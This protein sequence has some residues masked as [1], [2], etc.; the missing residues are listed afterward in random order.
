MIDLRNIFLPD[1]DYMLIAVA[2]YSIVF[3]AAYE[4]FNSLVKEYSSFSST[5]TARP[6]TTYFRYHAAAAIYSCFYV[7]LFVLIYQLFLRYPVLIET[8][9]GGFDFGPKTKSLFDKLGDDLKLLS[10]MLTVILLTWGFEQINRTAK[11]DRKVRSFLHK[12][13]SIPGAVSSQVRKMRRS[14][15]NSEFDKCFKAF[16]DDLKNEVA[17][18]RNDQNSIEHIFERACHLYVHLKDWDSLT[19]DFYHY[20]AAHRHAFESIKVSFE[21]VGNNAE[22]YYQ[23]KSKFRKDAQLYAQLAEAKPELKLGNIQPRLITELKGYLREDLKHLLESI[24]IYIACAVYSIGK[25]ENRRNNLLRTMGF[26]LHDQKKGNRLGI[27]PNDLTIVFMFLIIVIPL[28]AI[29]AH[30][31]SGGRFVIENAYTHVVWTIMAMAVGLISV[32]VPTLCKQAREN[33]DGSFW[34]FLRPRHGDHAWFAYLLSGS[35]VGLASFMVLTLLCYLTPN[36]PSYEIYGIALRIMPWALVPFAVAFMLCFHLDRKTTPKFNS[37]GEGLATSMA[38]VLAG[39]VAIILSANIHSWEELAKRMHFS[40]PAAALLGFIIGSIFP[41]RYR[42]KATK[43]IELKPKLVDLKAIIE[44]CIKKFKNRADNEKIKI[45]GNVAPNIKKLKLDPNRIEQAITSLISNAIE[46]TPQGGQITVSANIVGKSAIHL[47][48]RDSGIGMSEKKIA[49]VVN[50][51]K[52]RLNDAWRDAE[53]R[54]EADLY[55]IRFIA[56]EHGGRFNVKSTQLEGT[57]VMIELPE[58]LVIEGM[59]VDHPNIL[60]E[61]VVAEHLQVQA[62]DGIEFQGTPESNTCGAGMII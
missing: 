53:E 55:Q 35:T 29:F 4:R 14:P 7:I 47:S 43:P 12:L 38:A 9:K 49:A 59:S 50:A 22:R 28:A 26:E 54:Q 13:G 20:H 2:C 31:I 45:I 32:V 10:P 46:F 34:Q 48:V 41:K 17:L 21:K 23:L 6:W 19:S 5:G 11:I 27:D 37:L 51:S 52:E 16:P 44:K 8:I 58:E 40:I 60:G 33:L 15:L 57:E 3:I 1:T 25:S 61:G 36:L 24:Y 39:I 56:E 18:L 30:F 62:A 42:L